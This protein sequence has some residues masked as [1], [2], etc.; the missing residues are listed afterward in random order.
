MPIFSKLHHIRLMAAATLLL[1]VC[2]C[3]SDGNGDDPTPT[4]QIADS[5][6][7]IN[8]S[9]VVSSGN[10]KATRAPLGGEDGDGR[11]AGSERE[12]R[13]RG[14]TFMLY[15]SDEDKGTDGL[16]LS[17]DETLSFIGYYP[18]QFVS[19]EDAG[20]EYGQKTDEAIYT[21]GDQPL[22]GVVLSK[23][24]HAIVVA[25]ADLTTA[26]KVGD[27]VVDVLDHPMSIIYDG[28]GL[29]VDANYF[30]MSSEEGYTM[31]FETMTPTIKDKYGKPADVYDFTESPIR[32]ERLAAR[33]D[34]WM[35]NAE[36]RAKGENETYPLTAGYEYSVKKY[37]GGDSEDKFVLTAI[38]PF[39]LYNDKEYLIKRIEDDGETTYLKDETTTSYVIDPLRDKKTSQ[40]VNSYYDNP[41]NGLVDIDKNKH[42]LAGAEK[43]YQLLYSSNAQKADFTSSRGYDNFIICYPKENTLLPNSPLYYY[44]TGL[45]I[46][47]DYY[48]KGSAADK[49][50]VTHLIY[51]GYLRHQGEPSGAEPYTIKAAIDL[52]KEQTGAADVAMNFGVVRNNIYR[53]SIDQITEKD[54]QLR[55]TVKKWDTFTHDIIHM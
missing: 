17:G 37:F 45:A 15:Q 31:D 6:Q 1:L 39:N 29:G 53:I 26:F 41:L 20:T 52:D 10:E 36:Y 14:I 8:L 12:N 43:F 7:Y 34:F 38:T 32:I 40:E 3:S 23:K 54:I 33:V 35:N 24:Y 28:T 48:P 21:T 49:S 22:K 27:K 11:E 9:I 13:V 55:I 51:Y 50:K 5:N 19:R 2:A 4:P 44:A 47:G 30:V 18:V 16:S 46:E 42:T 25:N